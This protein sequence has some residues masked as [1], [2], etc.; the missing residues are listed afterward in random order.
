[1]SNGELLVGTGEDWPYSAGDLHVSF[2]LIP[3]HS[4]YQ[5]FMCFLSD[6]SSCP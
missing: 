1:M 3:L 6:L 2:L 5:F 4:C